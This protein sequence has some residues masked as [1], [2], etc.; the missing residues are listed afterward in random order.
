MGK[1]GFL[2][3]MVR[4]E[5]NYSQEARVM[6]D[7]RIETRNWKSVTKLVPAPIHCLHLSPFTPVI[8]YGGQFCGTYQ[9]F[10][11]IRKNLN[12]PFEPHDFLHQPGRNIAGGHHQFW[13]YSRLIAV[14][15]R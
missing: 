15:I 6:K 11:V 7:A 9:L 1:T 2:C 5:R 3:F 14:I 4:E 13:R 12:G 10:G 8:F